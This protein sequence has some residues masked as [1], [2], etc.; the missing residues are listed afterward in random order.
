MM[1]K[2]YQ[3]EGLDCANC[4][5]EVEEYLNKNEAIEKAVIDF[6]GKKIFITFK[7]EEL[8][9]EAISTLIADVEDGVTLLDPSKKEEKGGEEESEKGFMK[10]NEIKIIR[11]V[12]SSVLL[13]FAYFWYQLPFVAQI[14]IYVVSYLS[15]GYDVVLSMFKG[16]AKK[17]FFTEYSLMTVATIGALC[18]QEFP[19]AVLVMILYQIGELL[20]DAAV[21]HSRNQIKNA[22]EIRPKEAMVYRDNTWLTVAPEDLK[23]GEKVEVKVGEII[24][25]DGKILEGNGTVDMAHITGESV[26]VTVQQEENLYSGSILV[27]GHIFMEVQKSYADSTVS[28][29]LELL[30]SSSEKKG[31]AEKFVSKFASIYT[32][33]VFLVALLVAVIFPIFGT[34]FSKSI[35]NALIFLVV[36]CPC[37]IVISVP[38]TSFVGMGELA[39]RGII[40]KGSNYLD[41]LR[42][43]KTIV[44]DKT[45]TLTKG[46]LAVEKIVSPSLDEKELLEYVAYAES[47]SNHPIAKAIVEAYGKEV[48]NQQISDA[49]EILG[50]GVHIAY[51]NHI[52]E[53]GNPKL[54]KVD[55]IA[56]EP[57]SIVYVSVD[58]EYKGYIVLK[59]QLKDNA[60]EFV[61]EAHTMNM[62]VEMLSGDK[63]E[64]AELVADQ[65]GLDDFKGELLPEE[66]VSSLEKVLEV[67]ENQPVLYMGDGVNDAPSIMR[68]DVG[69]AMGAVGSEAAIEAADMVIMNDD[70][71]SVITSCKIAKKV[72]RTSIFNIAF[73]LTIKFVVY[74]L[75]LFNISSMW[76]ALLAD[77]GVT[78]LLIFHSLFL[79]NRLKKIK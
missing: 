68:A 61:K 49:Q 29:I 50:K 35:Y 72:Y 45:G 13:A 79:S 55:E 65:L 31:K 28:K 40:V 12:V 75:A 78:L 42:S 59:D 48:D 27:S 51:K 74:V 60:I 36:S 43:A 16:F 67:K 77:V 56:K 11:L 21:D 17:R 64:Y 73:A 63:K 41:L 23:I 33:I 1:R 18:I 8:S 46:K 32:P 7:N 47:I 20:Q 6:M 24:P 76:M 4:A 19:E 2:V 9:M 25:A 39:H 5:R 14:I 54:V 30:E 37:A 38:L 52:V 57:G 26:P 66:K 3:I 53:V 15:A 70:L 10:E 44:C 71:K 62:K 69:V 34:P 58:G 22:L